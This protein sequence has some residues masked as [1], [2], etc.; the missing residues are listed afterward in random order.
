MEIIKCIDCK[1]RSDE[2]FCNDKGDDTGLYQC[3]GSDEKIQWTN[4]RG[5]F[6]GGGMWGHLVSPDDYCSYAVRR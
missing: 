3:I 4:R 2:E 1:Y 5:N 6:Y